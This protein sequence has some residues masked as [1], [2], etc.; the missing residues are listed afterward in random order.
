MNAIKISLLNF[1]KNVFTYVLVLLE[2]SVLFL[3]VN[4]LVSVLKE[5]EMFIAP[6]RCALHENAAFVDDDSSASNAALYGMTELQSR[7]QLLS[8]ISDDYKIYDVMSV[9]SGDYIVFSLS[10]EMY[11]GLALPLFNGNYKSAV[12]TFGTKRGA[13]EIKFS[14][15]TSLTLVTSGTL[16][17][18]TSIPEMNSSKNNMTVNDLYYTSVNE[19]NII[20]TNRSSISGYEY[21]F[22]VNPFFFIEFEENASK[23]FAKIQ[24]KGGIVTAGDLIAENSRRALESDLSGTVPLAY[25][26]TFISLLGIVFVSV[27]TFKGNERKNAVFRLCGYSGIGIVG[28]HCVGIFLLTILSAG[29]AAAAFGIMKSLKIEAA[30]GLTLS[31]LNLFVSLVTIAVLILAAAVV[32]M[33]MTA[34]R[35]PAEY[36]RK[37]L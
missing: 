13:H 14:D 10:D 19:P 28:I 12:G 3:T 25:L 30:V 26:I 4:Y 23:N 18:I 31:P 33:I 34:K 11:N 32:P 36:F 1:K 20:L 37:V 7:E 24:N 29:V 27:I 2:I 9:N 22:R 8:D 21:Q 6:F 17:A 5:R 35:T 16:T 15:G